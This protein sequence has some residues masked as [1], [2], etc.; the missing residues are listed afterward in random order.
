MGFARMRPELIRNIYLTRSEA[1]RYLMRS[2]VAQQAAITNIARRCIRE[3]S[4]YVATKLVLGWPVYAAERP[5]GTKIQ[6]HPHPFPYSPNQ[7]KM[8]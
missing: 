1:R 4:S 2:T 7:E 5:K 8:S 6:I 3:S